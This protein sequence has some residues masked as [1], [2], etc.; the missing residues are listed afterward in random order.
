LPLSANADK[1]GGMVSLSD[2]CGENSAC[3]GMPQQ[4][5]ALGHPVR[6]E[7]VLSLAASPAC[8]C[9][10]LCERMPLAQSTVSQHLDVL[11][12]AGIVEWRAD[13]NRSRYTLNRKALKA[14]AAA[15]GEIAETLP[16]QGKSA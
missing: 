14:V 12:K 5:K 11:R 1:G 4:L 15:L 2:N 13:G 9:G 3:C 16:D 7:I 10:E 6:I 8:C